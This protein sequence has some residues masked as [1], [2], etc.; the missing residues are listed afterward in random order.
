MVETKSHLLY[1]AL[2]IV[3]CQPKIQRK[4]LMKREGFDEK[5]AQKWIDSQL[6]LCEKEKHAD[7]LIDNSGTPAVLTDIVREGWYTLK[8]NLASKSQ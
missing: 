8:K 6:P 4:R 2:I 7:L 1:D 5:T 3:T